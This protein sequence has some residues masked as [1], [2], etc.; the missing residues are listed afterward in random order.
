MPPNVPN[1]DSGIAM[2]GMVVER[3]LLRKT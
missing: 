2:L 3:T 1:S